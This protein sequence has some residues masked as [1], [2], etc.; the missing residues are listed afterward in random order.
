MLSPL[1]R[2]YILIFTLARNRKIFSLAR[3]CK[4]NSLTHNRKIF[5][6]VRDRKIFS[7]SPWPLTRDRKIFSTIPWRAIAKYS[8]LHLD[9]KSQDILLFIDAKS[10]FMQLTAS[11]IYD[12]ASHNYDISLTIYSVAL[13]QNKKYADLSWLILKMQHI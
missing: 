12:V 6:F 13:L 1:T 7:S 8:P 4:I 5:S 2:C 3:N 10:Q 11:L 9:A